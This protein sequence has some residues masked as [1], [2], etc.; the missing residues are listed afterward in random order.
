MCNYLAGATWRL[1]H[2]SVQDK[3]CNDV[4]MRFLRTEW[5][6]FFNQSINQSIYIAPQYRGA[7]YSAVKCRI[8]EKCLKTDFKCVNGWSSSTV[9]WEESSEFRSSNRETTSSSVQVVRRNWQKLLPYPE[10]SDHVC[11]PHIHPESWMKV[12]TQVSDVT[13]GRWYRKLQFTKP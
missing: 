4:C 5:I 3:I 9:Q 12:L 13:G 7:C 1:W 10:S 8:K 11:L 2:V 6:C